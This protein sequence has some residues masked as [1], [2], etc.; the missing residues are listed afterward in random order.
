[1]KHALNLKKFALG[2]ILILIL[3]ISIIATIKWLGEAHST[4]E[5]FVGVEFAYSDD[6]ND[7]KALVNKVKDYTNL[8][9]IGSLGIS[10]NQ[11]ALDEACD[12]IVSSGLHLIVFF[13][14]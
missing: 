13:Y 7:L 1:M 3:S 10:F 6:V 14:R 8:F 9:V 5:F 11:T 12:Y 4:S 2:I